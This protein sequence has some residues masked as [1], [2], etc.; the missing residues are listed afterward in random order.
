MSQRTSG[1]SVSTVSIVLSEAPLSHFVAEGTRERVKAAALK[2]GYHPNAYARS[3][4]R[5][6]SQTI[7]VLAYDLSDPFCLLIV[8]GIHA[9][10]QPS[11]YLPL[12]M[13]SQTER[14]CFDNYLRMILERPAEG[15]I[16][17]LPV[18]SLRRTTFLK[19]SER[20]MFPL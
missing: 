1:V 5:R 9:G 19:M 16:V 3:L 17:I 12:L 7:G 10:L 18:G 13:D 15:I 8:R 20:T 6:R 11:G 2:L 4:R 14:T